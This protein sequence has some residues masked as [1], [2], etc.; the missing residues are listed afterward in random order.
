LIQGNLSEESLIEIFCEKDKLVFRSI[1]LE[2]TL[3][4]GIGER[5]I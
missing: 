4:E 1:R 3:F 5:T 2:E